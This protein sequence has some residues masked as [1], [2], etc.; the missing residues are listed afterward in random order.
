M[1]DRHTRKTLA[2][3]GIDT[4]SPAS[5]GLCGVV[6]VWAAE[7][8]GVISEGPAVA[9]TVGIALAAVLKDCIYREPETDQS[10]VT[11]SGRQ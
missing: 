3:L 6:A 11:R 9:V 1:A 5:A 2:H 8:A 7:W 10:G 4:P